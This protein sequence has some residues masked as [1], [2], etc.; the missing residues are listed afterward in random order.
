M[1]YRSIITVVH[2]DLSPLTLNIKSFNLGM[3][4]KT[5]FGGLTLSLD[6]LHYLNLFNIQPLVYALTR[7]FKPNSCISDMCAY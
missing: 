5:I 6:K 7:L 1:E 2:K 4:C 3:F